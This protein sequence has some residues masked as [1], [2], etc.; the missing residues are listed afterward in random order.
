LCVFLAGVKSSVDRKT[1]K[2]RGTEEGERRKI[3]GRE[4]EERRKRRGR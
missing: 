2:F 3:R 1:H 4:E